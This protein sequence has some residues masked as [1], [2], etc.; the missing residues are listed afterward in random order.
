VTT[1][2]QLI[3]ADEFERLPD[4]PHGGKMELV[5]GRVVVMAP[6]SGGHGRRALR[7]GS[8]LEAFASQQGLGEVMVETGYRL[9]PDGNVRAPDVSFIGLDRIPAEGL[10]EEGYIP[11]AP[12]LAI[13]VVSPDDSDRDV[14]EKADEYLAAGAQRVWLVRPR[15]KTV[16]VFRAGGEAHHY[17]VDDTLTS[18]DAGFEVEGFELSLRELFS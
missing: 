18:A 9:S 17:T 3:T 16:T 4:P 13:E 15:T 7:L 11:G 6:V 12:T 8:R 14:G 1:V 2:E 10:A 5:D